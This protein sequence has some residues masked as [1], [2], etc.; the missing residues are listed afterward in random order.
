MTKTEAITQAQSEG[1]TLLQDMDFGGYIV[2]YRPANSIDGIGG[3]I[4]ELDKDRDKQGNEIDNRRHWARA[5]LRP[6][7]D[8]YTIGDWQFCAAPDME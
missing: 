4:G 8:G 6:N 2:A 5:I 3:H 1:A 7:G